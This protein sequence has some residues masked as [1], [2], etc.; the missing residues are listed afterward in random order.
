MPQISTVD[1]D[2]QDKKPEAPKIE[3]IDES[4]AY[5][6][7]SS[8]YSQFTNWR[9]RKR[10]IEEQW[11]SNLRAYN[12][13]YDADT[14]ST[15]DPN[16][17][18]QYIGI[19][20]MKTTAAYARLSD[21]I[22]PATGH[23]FWGIKPTPFPTLSS[24]IWAQ[25]ELEEEDEEGNRTPLTK[26]EALS[27]VT[28][29]MTAR[30]HDQLVEN[31][32]DTLI[33]SAIK[34]A[35]TFGSGIIKAGMI[36]V[37][38]KKS[39]IEGVSEWEQVKEEHIVPGMSQ[40]S[41][42]D[43]YFDINANSVDSSIGS[44]ERHILNKEEVRDLKNSA[45]FKEDVI[46][47]LV[48]DYPNGNHNR[49]H[50]EIER[51]TLGNITHFGNSGYYEV[52][53]YWGYIDGQKL[54]DAGV[55]IEGDALNAG[56]M[57]NVWTSGHKVLKIQID[58]SI[59]KGKK[60]FVFPYEQIPNQLWGVGVPEIMM[61]SQDVLNAA[62]RR[63]LDD[64]AMTGNQLE[65]NVD[66]LDDRSVNNANKI[67]PWKIWYRS[68]GDEAYNAITVHKV[69][70][71]GGELIQIIE[72]VRNFIDDETN[73]PSLISGQASQGGTPG[74]E[75][76]SGM[77]MLLGAAQVVIKTVVK[78]I[79][80]Y[81]I[82]PLITSYYNFNMEWSD[83]DEIK[84]DMNIEAL[85]SAIL[86]AREVQTRSMTEFLGITANEFD[87]PLVKRPN[88]LRKIAKNMGLD[89]DD[90][91][92]D[93]QLRAEAAKPDPM[94]EKLNDLAIE[95]AELENAEIQG[96]IDVLASEELKNNAEAKYK[97]EF[98][99]QRRVKLAEDIKETRRVNKQ[100][101]IDAKEKGGKSEKTKVSGKAEP[102]KILNKD[103]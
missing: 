28:K 40:P 23:K 84:G 94:E 74:A 1:K 83:D 16:G 65:I 37:E 41:P 76:A 61:D 22:F 49:E 29:R 53:E 97:Q 99:R 31:N 96:R 35:C 79:D 4:V 82:K 27:E 18:T 7:G 13:V 70:S 21:I 93:K 56:Y 30:I 51:Q 38:R 2:K 54:R 6:L 5:A 52:L 95:K 81:L 45:G 59:N 12:S 92:S 8:L 63:L 86:V 64:V 87:M 101:A 55:E 15:F 66:R 72:M 11:L 32:A 80:D 71:I 60:Y 98:L 69:P 3:I 26:E 50:H 48:I 78:N 14:R 25:D 20:R 62:F 103:T 17:S 42:F 47:Q 102:V 46:N 100:N 39:W 89:E 33:R 57:A 90:I 85:G 88:I 58:D 10:K 67:K 75:T 24:E 43:V 73:L 68:G 36:T 19:T 77:S 44:Y 34:D 91:K 9:D